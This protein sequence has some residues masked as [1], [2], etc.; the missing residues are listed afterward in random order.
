M[1][2]KYGKVAI[3]ISA[4][5]RTGI[6]ANPCFRNFFSHLEADVFY[7]TW[8][9]DPS[10]ITQLA[11]LYSPVR[12]QAVAP[13]SA[14][15]SFGSM[16]YSIMMANEMKKRYELENN[17]R[18]DLVIKTRF[19][20][21]FPAGISF[22]DVNIFPRSVCSHWGSTGIGHI[23][24]EHTGIGDML[25]WGDSQSMDIVTNTYMY[26]KH[27]ALVANAQLIAGHTFDPDDIYFSPGALI[28]H[29]GSR[30]NIA[31][32]RYTGYVGAVPWRDDVSHLDPITD[33]DLIRERY[34]RNEPY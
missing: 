32:E 14:M 9:T 4:L 26:Y 22:P 6:R 19:D 25:F 12:Y 17:F 15:G 24:T 1:A 33:Y 10:Q 31:F 34:V 20:L 23:D 18:Y 28:Q 21:V 11:D 27:T 5:P 2:S 29:R 30:R 8:S 13:K 7:H 16:F 3:C